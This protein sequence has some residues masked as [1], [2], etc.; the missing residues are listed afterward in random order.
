MAHKY[1]FLTSFFLCLIIFP[2]GLFG[3]S[4][5]PL[6]G[7]ILH[8]GTSADDNWIIDGKLKLGKTI[9]RKGQTFSELEISQI[10]DN[11]DPLL[12]S[13]LENFKEPEVKLVSFEAKRTLD[14]VRI[15][16]STPVQKDIMNYSIERSQDGKNWKTLYTTF[17]KEGLMGT[18]TY[19]Y[20][21]ENPQRG[22][23]FYRLHQT[24]LRGKSEFSQS[25]AVE[26][27]AMMSHI[28]YLY[29]NPL[30][31]GT[32]IELDLYKPELVDIRIF[33]QK[34][35][36]VA[37]IY[38]KNTSVGEH[39]IELN[40]DGLPKGKY[41]CKIKVGKAETLREINR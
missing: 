31:F 27:M 1:F 21:D 16:W 36:E 34:Q 12:A 7:A 18:S 23:N 33:N 35:E 3:Q 2:K 29:P 41:L 10:L 20:I 14:G 17:P 39:L 5:V 38:S 6:T 8:L 25:M 40:M 13:A 11:N 37:Q 30:I 9:T 28:T 19:E 24:S 22:T 32:S 4:A 26:V 15:N